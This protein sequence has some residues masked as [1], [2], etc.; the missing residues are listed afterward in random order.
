VG[1]EV[2]S[3]FGADPLAGF[4]PPRFVRLASAV[5]SS[6]AAAASPGK[7][8]ADLPG[9]ARDVLHTVGVRHFSGGVWCTASEPSRFFSFRRD[10][11][12]GR[13]AASIC[14]RPH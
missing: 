12:T 3:S 13:Q 8:L 7:W 6:S 5:H 1:A 9:L 14:L 2:L 10:R 4:D 11:V